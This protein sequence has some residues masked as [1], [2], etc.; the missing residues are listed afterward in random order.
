MQHK[1][2]ATTPQ[3]DLEFIVSEFKRLP[4]VDIVRANLCLH[5]AERA[6]ASLRAASPQ[7]GAETW[8]CKHCGSRDIHCFD[9]GASTAGDTQKGGAE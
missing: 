1:I 8:T 9:C 6:L 2:E 4:F 3:Q 7:G 5:A